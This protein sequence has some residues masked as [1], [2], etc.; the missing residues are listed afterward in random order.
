[1]LVVMVVVVV[2]VVVV[3]AYVRP[4]QRSPGGGARLCCVPVLSTAATGRP[5]GH[6]F[7]HG[8]NEPFLITLF[9]SFH[10]PPPPP[11]LI[12]FV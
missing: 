6:G 3:V 12:I 7:R 9:I 4:I 10:P 2:V 5:Q 11:H 1:M 8:A